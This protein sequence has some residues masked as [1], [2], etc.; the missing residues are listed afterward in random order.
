MKSEVN[1]SM[2]Y[3]S[4]TDPTTALGESECKDWILGLDHLRKECPHV[5]YIIRLERFLR[6]EFYK[7]KTER[8]MTS[9]LWTS[10]PPA[11]PASRTLIQ[12][13]STSHLSPAAH[14]WLTALLTSPLPSTQQGPEEGGTGSRGSLRSGQSLEGSGAAPLAPTL[15]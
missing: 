1:H 13:T 5:P 12:W 3:S 15:R 8:T 10:S 2:T 6:T 14:T 9:L 11:T 4:I 7:W